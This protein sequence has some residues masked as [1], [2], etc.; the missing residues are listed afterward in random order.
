MAQRCLLPRILP[1]R[2]LLL[3][4]IPRTKASATDNTQDINQKSLADKPSEEEVIDL[5][6][7]DSE[8]Q[9]DVEVFEQLELP[10]DS[11][12][13]RKAKRQCRFPEG[14]ASQLHVG[15]E[16]FEQY[17]EVVKGYLHTMMPLTLEFADLARPQYNSRKDCGWNL[18]LWGFVVFLSLVSSVDV[19]LE[20]LVYEAIILLGQGQVSILDLQKYLPRA[21][22]EHK[23]KRGVYLLIVRHEKL[24]CWAVYDGSSADKCGRWISGFLSSILA[25][26][27]GMGRRQLKA[28]NI[29]TSPDW[30]VTVHEGAVFS[31]NRHCLWMYVLEAFVMILLDTVDKAAFPRTV[32]CRLCQTC[33]V[34]ECQRV[35]CSRCNRN[36]FKL[37]IF[38]DR[39]GRFVCNKCCERERIDRDTSYKT[40]L[41]CDGICGREHGEEKSQI[42]YRPS[43]GLSL[44]KTCWSQ[45]AQ[46]E[47]FGVPEVVGALRLQ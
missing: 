1:Y 20:A 25:L 2:R 38:A 10:P 30:T 6:S 23:S 4:L 17:R 21:K 44:C 19:L 7:Q 34:T 18:R 28:Y 22:I 45:K 35:G 41:T 33:W 36:A 27:L 47:R 11:K 37:S 5:D 16:H 3:R 15:P 46:A 13:L 14:E 40:V 42:I 29:L 32:R 26:C 9:D 43:C 24:D 39:D 8:C 12:A 31:Q